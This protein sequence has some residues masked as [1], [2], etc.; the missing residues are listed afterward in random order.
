MNQLLNK[1]SRPTSNLQLGNCKVLGKPVIL[2]N[3]G[4]IYS[5]ALRRLNVD[6]HTS[7]V[8]YSFKRC[9]VN[10]EIVTSKTY[11]REKKHS[12]CTVILKNG[13]IF[14]IE[15]SIRLRQ[16]DN[17]STYLIGRYYLLKKKSLIRDRKLDHLIPLA[18]KLKI[19][20]AVESDMVVQKVMIITLDDN[21]CVAYAH[22][23]SSKMLS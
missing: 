12:N 5:L 19:I 1:K 15:N 6:F 4:K 22:S 20:T 16:S 2:S 14:E 23:C 13:Q 10:Q 11:N 7:T 18:E 9:I 17:T 21:H 8:I 3:L